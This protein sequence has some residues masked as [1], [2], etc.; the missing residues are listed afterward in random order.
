[1]KINNNYNYNIINNEQLSKGL[2][3]WRVILRE[4]LLFYPQNC[5]LF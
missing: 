1:M 4:K 3:T 2:N 5:F